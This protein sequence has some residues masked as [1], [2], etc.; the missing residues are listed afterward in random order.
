MIGRSPA[1]LRI[2]HLTRFLCLAVGILFSL[3]ALTAWGQSPA[4]SSIGPTVDHTKTSKFLKTYCA[5]CHGPDTQESDLRLDQLQPD[6]SHATTASTWIEVMDKINLG[7]M[8]PEGSTMPSSD[9][10]AS[11]ADWIASELRLAERTKLS[12]QGRVILR[13]MNRAEYA[14]TVRDLLKLNFLPGESPESLLPPDGTAEGFDKVSVAL[15]LDP[16]LLDKYFEVAQRIADS[17]IVEGPPPFPTEKMRLEMEDIAEN[18]AIHYL[19]ATPGIECLEKAIVLMQGSTRSYGVM[20]YPGLRQ[21]IPIE[22]MY[23][24]RVRAWGEPGEDGQ[25]VVMR[26]RQDHPSADQQ[27]LLETEVTETPQ[28]YEIVV[29]R[30]PKCGEYNVSIVNETGFQLS[31]RVGNDIRRLQQKAGEA[32]DFEQVMRLQSRQQMENLTWGKPNPD[33]ADRTKLRKLVVDWLE[34][35]GPLYEQWPPKSHETLFFRGEAAEENE[36]YLHDIFARFLPQAFRRPVTPDEIDHVVALCQGELDAGESFHD[37]VRTGLVAVLCSP[38]FLYLSEPSA[39]V[40]KRPLDDWELASRL[41]YFL[42]SSM[43]DEQLFDLARAGKLRDPQTLAEQVDR[44][45]ADEKVTGLTNGFG[46]QW[47]KTGEFRNF[48]PDARLYRAYDE[49]LGE[50]MVRQTLAFFDQILRSDESALAFIDSDWTMLNERL[51]RFYEIEGIKGEAFRRVSLPPGS[52]RGGLLGM[53]GVAMRGSDGNRTK[54]VNRGV[55]VRDVLFNDPPNPPPPNA[56]EVEP[57]IQGERLTV[58]ERLVQHQQIAS[59]AACHRTIDSY[60]FALENFNVIGQWRDQQDG[61]DFR[62]RNAPPID[63]S[64]T[65]PNGKAFEGFVQFKSLLM[66]QDERFARGLA[67]KML[68]YAL[69]RPVEP[70]DR[71]LIDELANQMQQQNYTLSS[72]IRGIVLSDAFQTK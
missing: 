17:A 39:A 71:G 12:A 36:P 42:W 70:G 47:L 56:G 25:P 13:R 3:S 65:L 58:R 59:C 6:F 57:N 2:H 55:Y 49:K 38:K 31:S 21:E 62:G 1:P 8:P 52:P 37:A 64:G 45:L 35:E 66:E 61:E 53:A 26:V 50:A 27:L 20:K 14:N 44:M 72:L 19:C 46:A 23:R 18:R 5:E 43:P 41:S 15:M 4:D 48:M 7:E 60:G 34:C 24:I 40:D 9:E 69:G 51:A 30:D 11:V 68:V 54:P 63:A 22:G 67:E 10:A 28:V 16:S 32:K 33:A 29:P